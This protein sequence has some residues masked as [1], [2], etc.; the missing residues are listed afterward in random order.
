MRPRPPLPAGSAMR[1]RLPVGAL[2]A[3]DTLVGRHPRGRVCV[4]AMGPSYSMCHRCAETYDISF[5][6]FR[7]ARCLR[8][9]PPLAPGTPLTSPRLNCSPAYAT[10]PH[11]PPTRVCE[12]AR[13]LTTSVNP[14]I[15]TEIC[16]VTTNAR[17]HER[18][19]ARPPEF[20]QARSTGCGVHASSPDRLG[21]PSKP[22]SPALNSKGRL[23]VE[24]TFRGENSK[25]NRRTELELEGEVASS[26]FS[27]RM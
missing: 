10:G 13:M 17:S 4:G 12:S 21:S 7:P 3:V 27:S 15:C 5:I 18:M 23:E 25:A 20:A 19:F 9:R 8:P 24:F 6:I 16:Y 22:E 1:E 14:H 26:P 2:V 11:L